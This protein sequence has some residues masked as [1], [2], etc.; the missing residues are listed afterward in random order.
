MSTALFGRRARLFFLGAT[1]S[2][3]PLAFASR[4]EP[5]PLTEREQMLVLIAAAGNT[6]WQWT[7][8]AVAPKPGMISLGD[9]SVSRDLRAAR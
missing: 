2:E 7:H 8:G 5:L 3:G 4:H 9:H 6:G 1:I